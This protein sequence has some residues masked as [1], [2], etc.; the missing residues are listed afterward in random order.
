MLFRSDAV[1]KTYAQFS[2]AATLDRLRSQRE[3]AEM[4]NANVLALDHEPDSARDALQELVRTVSKANRPYVLLQLGKL[5]R[6]LNEK[7]A[8]AVDAYEQAID[9]MRAALDYPQE[10]ATRL[11]LAR[12]LAT[13]AADRVPDAGKKAAEQLAESDEIA[14]RM[15]YADAEWRLDY[16][17]GIL[18]EDKPQAAI[19]RYRQAVAKLDR[20]R[21]GLSQQEQRQSF[22]DNESVEDLYAR[23]IALLT[24]AGLRD[25]A[26]R[27]L[28]NGKARSFLEALQGRRF[29]TD[30]ATP[31]MAQLQ[32][33]EKQMEIGR[34]HV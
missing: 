23:L 27:Y 21:S 15:Q 24:R 20:M 16:L 29:A 11:T 17:H 25:D 12:Y 4:G 3:E 8:A 33:L 13:K 9:G 19:E 31:A 34:A 26:W 32:G 1:L 6:T 14:H 10:L 5:E 22:L 28:E 30:S 7:P 2:A 18:S